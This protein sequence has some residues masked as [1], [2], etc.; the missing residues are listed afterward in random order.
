[1]RN[2]TLATEIIRD[3]KKSMAEASEKAM[4]ACIILGK[5]A[6]DD[7]SKECAELLKSETK[8]LIDSIGTENELDQRIIK[9]IYGFARTGFLESIAGKVGEE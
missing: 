6:P 5:A 2:E 4:E 8:K 9:L 7:E 3:M 1:M